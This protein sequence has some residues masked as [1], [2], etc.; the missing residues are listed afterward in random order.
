MSCELV[1]AEN[2]RISENLERVEKELCIIIVIMLYSILRALIGS[3]FSLYSRKL[4]ILGTEQ[5]IKKNQRQPVSLGTIISTPA[6]TP[7][8]NLSYCY[9]PSVSPSLF[10]L[11][12]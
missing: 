5:K 4:N 11:C 12:M 10:L 9:V 1:F 2:V 7:H 8:Q 6:D 3:G